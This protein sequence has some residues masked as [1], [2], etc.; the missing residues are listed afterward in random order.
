MMIRFN[1]LPL[2]SKIETLD[3]VLDAIWQYEVTSRNLTLQ[4]FQTTPLYEAVLLLQELYI[5]E[6]V[7]IKL[8]IMRYSVSPS[9][10]NFR[11]PQRYPKG[12]K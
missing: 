12:R 3:P 1:E 6:R 10:R 4:P 8:E 9:A 11:Q 7:A 2:V 5:S